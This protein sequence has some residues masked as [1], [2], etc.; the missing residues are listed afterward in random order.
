MRAELVAVHIPVASL[1]PILFPGE[2]CGGHASSRFEGFMTLNA[3]D[4]QVA[5]IQYKPRLLMLRQGKGGG[6]KTLNG[7]TGPTIAPILAIGKL[8]IMTVLV[9][10]G[11]G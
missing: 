8:T 1:T 4:R 9:T 2:P 7:M 3:R 10:G 6:L 5:T 11:A